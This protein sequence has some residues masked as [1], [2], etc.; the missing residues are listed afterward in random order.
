MKATDILAAFASS[1]QDNTVPW[2]AGEY[3]IPSHMSTLFIHDQQS[4][5]FPFPSNEDLQRL[6]NAAQPASFGRGAEAVLDPTYRSA[7]TLTTENFAINFRP[8]FSLLNQIKQLMVV[9]TKKA[10][11]AE[12]IHSD[13]DYN[14]RADLYRVNIYGPGDFFKEHKDTPQSEEGHFGSLVFCLPTH[15]EGGELMLRDL[16][17]NEVKFDWG[18]KFSNAKQSIVENDFYGTQETNDISPTKRRKALV[19]ER[20]TTIHY[21]A[22]ASDLNHWIEPVVSG[23]RVTVTYHLFREAVEYHSLLAQPIKLR[24]QDSEEV[25]QLMKCEGLKGKQVVFP[26]VHQYSSRSNKTLVLKGGDAALFQSLQQIGVNPEVNFYYKTTKY[27]ASSSS[28]EEDDCV[29]A[30]LTDEVSLYTSEGLCVES[31]NGLHQLAARRRV[32]W[33]R[34]PILPHIKLSVT[35]CYGNEPSMGT[36]SG[37]ACISTKF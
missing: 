11:K 29:L 37:N 3:E 34:K 15:F 22:F 27:F 12:G 23:Y 8:D 4:I 24:M 2:L 17:C 6:Y 19:S 31:S 30:Y 13:V 20:S 26:L 28:D 33:A 1:I 9:A 36:Y 16:Q 25:R 14:V 18:S 32:I 35:G 10:N 5:Q 21:L 7:R